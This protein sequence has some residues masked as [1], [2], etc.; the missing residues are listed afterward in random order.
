MSN[1]KN[2]YIEKEICQ[3]DRSVP[4][5]SW[6]HAIEITFGGL[7]DAIVK[8]K[9]LKLRESY[10]KNYGE[11]LEYLNRFE[12]AEINGESLPSPPS[13][14]GKRLALYPSI[15]SNTYGCYSQCFCEV[16]R[17]NCV[18]SPDRLGRQQCLC[19]G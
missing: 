17:P 1:S 6:I 7:G 5:P 16:R 4:R 9:I 10:S 13:S 11:V 12:A 15:L 8:E 3:V 18:D 14:V 19:G 2:L